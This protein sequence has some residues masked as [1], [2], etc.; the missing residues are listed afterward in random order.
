MKT[1]L[2]F[3]YKLVPSHF[4]KMIELRRKQLMNFRILA[5]DYGQFQTI[6]KWSCLDSSGSPIPWYTYPAIEYLN[7]LD[8]SEMNVFEFGSGNSTI[9]WA[10]KAKKVTSVEDN[11]KWY[12]QIQSLDTFASDKIRYLLET[13][14][15]NYI[16]SLSEAND[17]V[18]IDG[19]YRPECTDR[20]LNTYNIE[21]LTMLI[22]D[23][24]DWYPATIQ[25]LR[26]KFKWVQ[27][28]FHG[29]GP[30]NN[31]TWT[32]TIFINPALQSRLNYLKSLQSITSI[33]NISDNE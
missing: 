23:N 13:N 27:V 25:K 16:N 28:D 33:H 18:V 29:F 12:N 22:F 9:W 21:K 4:K 19:K 24:S 26:E 32:T 11:E 17:I 31:Y 6:K 1:I 8:F 10:G 2:S 20:L 14:K 5:K 30:I 15:S 7:H 3:L